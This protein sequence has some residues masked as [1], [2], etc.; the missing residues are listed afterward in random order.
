[1]H[2]KG[3]G[4][5]GHGQSLRPWSRYKKCEHKLSKREFSTVETMST[6]VCIVG[7]GPVGM[8]LAAIL[9]K[10]FDRKCLILERAKKL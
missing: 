3:I 4:L 6:D 2:R 9:Q 5:I 1:M 10:K 7:C 8:V